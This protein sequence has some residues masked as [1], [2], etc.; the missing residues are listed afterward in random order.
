MLVT[1]H[2]GFKGSWLGLWLELLGCDVVGLSLP[3]Q[4][5]SLYERAGLRGRWAEFLGDI[6]EYTVVEKCVLATQ[7]DLVFH[8][9]AQP[10]VSSG[11]ADPLGT[12]STNVTG[13][14]H[15]AE[16][17]RKA[18]SAVGCV[19]ITTDKVYRPR[20]GAHR[21]IE[22]DPL[23]A[24][25]PYS[26]SKAA[27]EHVVD[28]W[29]G[30]A[31]SDTT[32]VVARAGNVLG[33]GDFAANRLLP[34]LVRAFV[35]GQTCSVRHPDFTRPWQHVLDPLSGYILMGARLLGGEFV[36]EALNFGPEREET[37]ASVA[38]LA[39]RYWGK[40]AS[41]TATESGDMQE[42]RLLA[43]DSDLARR[44]VGWTPTWST[45]EAVR[46]TVH[47]WKRVQGGASPT[48]LCLGDISDF[49]LSAEW[50]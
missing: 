34:D 36:P 1:G 41:W 32:F 45:D 13:T 17:V 21:H 16:A 22:S 29:R 12:F 20:D 5:Y 35:S 2:T 28:A 23:G 7:P 25:D 19:V 40:G 6:R 49:M 3:P 4:E 42:T 48:S 50:S 15:V 8:L 46:R 27:A 31:D 26:A 14:M 18:S 47:W 39:V 44:T 43:L 38:D 37:V 24:S 11:Y 9:A 30:L 33:G 10:I